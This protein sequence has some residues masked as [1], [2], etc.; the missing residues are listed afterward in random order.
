M[1]DKKVSI[2][3]DTNILQTFLGSENVFLQ[4]LQIT[5]DYYD[6]INFVNENRLRDYIEICIPEVVLLECRQHMRSCFAK[7][8]DKIKQTTTEHQKLFG[9]LVDINYSLKITRKEYDEYLDEVFFEFSNNPRNQCKIVRYSR[10]ENLIDILLEKA[11]SGTKPFFK[12]KVGGKAHSDA[13]FKDSVIAETIYEYCK[14]NDTI[15]ILI[16][17]D[18]DFC[19]VFDKKLETDS[20]FVLFPSI[21]K[22]IE[23]LREFYEIDSKCRLYNEFSQNTYWHE[24]LL[25][26]AAVKFDE[27]VT[28]VIVESVTPKDGDDNVYIINMFFIVNE[29]KYSF[30]VQFDSIANDILDINYQIEND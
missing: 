13:G 6:L 27:S 15:G 26:N 12:G 18:N 3:L 23:S 25:N 19:D 8:E 21:E 7:N 10:R 17:Q 20:S 4:D 5:R 22:A 1:Q 2:F 11:L 30:T 9:T 29:V 28:K 24:Y 16:T 14:D